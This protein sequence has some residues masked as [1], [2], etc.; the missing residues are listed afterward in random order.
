MTPPPIAPALTP[1]APRPFESS[2]PKL[3]PAHGFTYP[4]A[5]ATVG[6]TITATAA[7]I[8][9]D[10]MRRCISL[11]VDFRFLGGHHPPPL[12]KVPHSICD[13]PLACQ[14]IAPRYTGG[15]DPSFTHSSMQPSLT[16]VC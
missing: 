8:T 1:N 13:L 3:T 4:S 10:L 16:R 5:R 15:G 14:F 6:A 7:P 2:L 12:R 11:T 9:S